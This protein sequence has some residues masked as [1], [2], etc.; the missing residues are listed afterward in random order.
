MN[1]KGMSQI[2]TTLII[3]VLVLVAIGVVW[4]VVS[5]LISD[6]SEE[7]SLGKFTINLDAQNAYKDGNGNVVVNLKRLAGKGDLTKIKFVLSDGKNSESFELEVTLEELEQ[8]SFT[9]TPLELDIGSI[10]S[11]EIAPIYK[12][13]SGSDTLGGITDTMVIA[14]TPPGEGTPSGDEECGNNI[15]EFGEVCDGT[16]LTP[17][18]IECSTHPDYTGGDLSCLGDCSGYNTDECT[19]E[20]CTIPSSKN[21]SLTLGVCAGAQQDCAGDPPEWPGC[22]VANYITHNAAYEADTELSCDDGLD[23]DCD[24]DIDNADSECEYTWTGTVREPWPSE[25]K[26]LFYVNETGGNY[27][28]PTYNYGAFLMYMSFSGGS[29][30]T[31]CIQIHDYILPYELPLFDNAIVSLDE[32]V[33]LPINIADGDTFTIYQKSQCGVF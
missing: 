16:A 29:S 23:N 27:T 8:G 7:V 32:T 31:R 13:G 4:G 20:V 10:T 22:S 6:S 30:E 2:V 33:D 28:N 17:Y 1:K 3:I 9:L 5:K 25:T 21:C 15:I 14:E 24:G 18:T 11:I 26:L 19:G 12:S